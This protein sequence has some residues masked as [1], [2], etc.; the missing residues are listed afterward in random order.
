[1]GGSCDAPKRT[2]EEYAKLGI[3]TADKRP[4]FEDLMG[5]P[6][7][8]KPK[9][10]S[11]GTN[12]GENLCRYCKEPLEHQQDQVFYL[13]KFCWLH[14]TCYEDMKNFRWKEN[15]KGSRHFAI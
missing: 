7:D 4:S 13:R 9:L 12:T 1:M 15:T 10:P 5:K 3:H 8:S 14:G 11:T 6:V 2:D